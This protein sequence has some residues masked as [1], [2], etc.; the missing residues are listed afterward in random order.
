MPK[1]KDKPNDNT[2]IKAQPSE[3]INQ[4][5]TKEK[6]KI[7]DKTKNLKVLESTE[8]DASGSITA[9]TW[10]AEMD[11]ANIRKATLRLGK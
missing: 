6:D 1:D 3:K 2:T 5:D 11:K 7:K 10:V 4:K 8:I 9:G